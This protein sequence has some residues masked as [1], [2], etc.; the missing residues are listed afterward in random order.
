MTRPRAFALH[1]LRKAKKKIHSKV[2][3]Y[4]SYNEGK[5]YAWVKP[6]NPTDP[7]ARNGKMWINTCDQFKDFCDRV[8]NCDS[9]ELAII[10]L[11]FSNSVCWNTVIMFTLIGIV[12]V[13]LLLLSKGLLLIEFSTLEVCNILA[14][15]FKSMHNLVGVSGNTGL[16]MLKNIFNIRK[17]SIYQLCIVTYYFILFFHI[18]ISI[19]TVI[20]RVDRSTTAQFNQK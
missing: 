3:R 2:A 8:L 16:I 18:P 9:T 13:S 7:R 12:F 17:L 14:V 11:V 4:G 5:V 10:G 19:N 15:S 6:P 1:E 20:N